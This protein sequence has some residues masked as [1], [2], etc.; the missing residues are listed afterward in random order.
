[1]A[2]DHKG[3]IRTAK[4]IVRDIGKESAAKSPGLNEL[5][6]NSEKNS[7]R[8]LQNVTSKKNAVTANCFVNHSETSWNAI[9]WRLP[10]NQS[11]ELVQV[12]CDI[13][14]LAC[15]V[16]PGPAQEFKP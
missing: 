2:Q 6:R 4:G 15:L 14:L 3:S 11:Q 7:E 16:W 10:C 1:M 5:A 13:L 12:S 8:D 9:R